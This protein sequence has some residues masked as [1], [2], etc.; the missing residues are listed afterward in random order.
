MDSFINLQKEYLVRD[1][2]DENNQGHW[3][4]ACGKDGERKERG[5]RRKNIY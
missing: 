4:W 5:R 1:F 2:Q 3:G